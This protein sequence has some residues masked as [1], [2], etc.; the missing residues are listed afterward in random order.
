MKKSFRILLHTGFWLGYLIFIAIIMFAASQG[1]DLDFEGDRA[2]YL[3]FIFRR[4][5]LTSCILFL[6]PL[7]LPLP[8]ISTTKKNCTVHPGWPGYLY[9]RNFL[10]AIVHQAHQ[11]RSY[12]MYYMGFSLRSGV[13]TINSCCFWGCCP[14]FERFPYLV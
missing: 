14:G 3:S 13:H 6:C 4:S 5:N 11:C 12:G 7:F 1:Q 10:G 8:Q 9:C 2:Y